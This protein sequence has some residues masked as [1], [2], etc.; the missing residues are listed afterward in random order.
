MKNLSFIK[1]KLFWGI[2]IGVSCA[3]F[4]LIS[5]QFR[6]IEMASTSMEPTITGQGNPP[7]RHGDEVLILKHFYHPLNRGDLVLV[8]IDNFNGTSATVR[9]VTGVSGDVNPDSTQPIPNGYYY[10]LGDS[11]N[12]IDSRQLGLVSNT[13]IQGKVVW[14][15]RLSH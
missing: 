9:R 15:I 14:I 1:S 8:M 13:K 4:L 11:T 5:S 10:L 7:V 2:L 12:A 3:G 6:L